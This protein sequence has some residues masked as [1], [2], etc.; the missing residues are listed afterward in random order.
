MT[1]DDLTRQEI[2]EIDNI[3]NEAKKLYNI[4]PAEYILLQQTAALLSIQN[5]ECELKIKILKALGFISEAVHEI[6]CVRRGKK[7]E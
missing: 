2:E 4:S 3:I 5:F 1:S 6:T 7:N